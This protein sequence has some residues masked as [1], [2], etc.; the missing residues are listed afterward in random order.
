MDSS[1]PEYSAGERTSTS[2]RPDITC[3]ITSSRNARMGGSLRGTTGYSVR[4]R[5]GTSRVSGRSSKTH[6]CRPP[7]SS[8]RSLWPNR[9]K[10]HSAY[11][12]HQL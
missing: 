3:A 1:S 7:L 8:R 4:G 6:F 10:T 5:V 12:A 11:A 9:E 2:A